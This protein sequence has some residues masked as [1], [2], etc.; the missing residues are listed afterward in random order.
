MSNWR[1]TTADG[2]AETLATPKAVEHRTKLT[3]TLVRGLIGALTSMLNEPA[4]PDLEGGVAMIVELAVGVAANV[5]LES[6]DVFVYYPL[7]GSVVVPETS[8][9]E[10]GLPPL[11]SGD[12]GSGDTAD[13][14]SLSGAEASSGGGESKDQ[15][16]LHESRDVDGASIKEQ[17]PKKKGGGMFGGLMGK[18]PGPQQ[19]SGGQRQGGASGSQSSLG[20][21]QQQQQQQRPT[22]SGESK[23]DTQRVRVAAFMAVEVRGRSILVKAPVWTL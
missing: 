16:S 6:R 10:T 18:K 5:P 23:E 22:S 12:G 8:K 3:Q 2:L 14:G 1:L 4:P 9:L 11:L 20:Q 19:E 21:Q 13:R 17:A 15:A 7:P